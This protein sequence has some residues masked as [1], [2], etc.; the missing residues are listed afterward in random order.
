[1]GGSADVVQIYC[2][3][4]RRTSLL[5]ESYACTSCICGLCGSCTDA[6]IQEQSRGRMTSCPRCH[7]MDSNFKPLQLELR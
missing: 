4:C 3:G 6:I 5:K 2:A 1:M 7:A